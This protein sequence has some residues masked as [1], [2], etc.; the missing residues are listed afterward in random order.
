MALK[1]L[2]VEH[3][4]N[5]FCD[6]KSSDIADQLNVVRLFPHMTS[7]DDINCFLKPISG[8]KVEAVL[9]GFK[10]DKSP[11]PDGWPIEFFLAFFNLVGG[12]SVLDVEART[13]GKFSG[14]LNSTF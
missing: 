11:G 2:G 7:D 12:E 4:S 10:N 1:A 5:L 13:Q 3:F 8:S 9:R 14:A 6:D